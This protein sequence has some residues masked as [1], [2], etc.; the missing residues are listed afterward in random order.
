M[1]S[2]P[3]KASEKNE[4][5][6]EAHGP[7]ARASTEVMPVTSEAPATTEVE[8]HG[9]DARI[10]TEEPPAVNRGP[11]GSSEREARQGL[12]PGRAQ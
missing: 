10:S 1:E 3:A 9:P 4:G 12:Q 8:A 11:E 5:V 2:H 7:D 6:L